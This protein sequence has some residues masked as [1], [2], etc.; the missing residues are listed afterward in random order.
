M[1]SG[2]SLDHFWPG[3]ID[4]PIGILYYGDLETRRQTTREN[5]RLP[6]IF[7]AF[8]ALGVEAQPVVYNDAFCTEV[9]QQV[10]GMDAVLTWVNP[11]ED[12]CNRTMLDALRRE[13]AAY[14]TYVSTHPD[15]ILKHGTKEVLVHTRELGWGS[16]T[17]LYASIAD[18]QR[19]LP[20]RLSRGEVRVLKQRRGQSGAG[21]DGVKVRHG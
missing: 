10:S 2:Q 15:T 14:G 5:V 4:N 6:N 11:I 9:K 21:V 3:R 20:D 16:D 19:E 17:H 1:R 18:M 12:G 13:L 8:E 7:E